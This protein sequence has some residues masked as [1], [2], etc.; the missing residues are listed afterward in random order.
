MIRTEVKFYGVGHP[1]CFSREKLIVVLAPKHIKIKA[2]AGVL[3]LFYSELCEE[4]GAAVFE[5]ATFN[6][7]ANSPNM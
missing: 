3:L 4:Q 2:A 5:T 6:R 7:S 1:P